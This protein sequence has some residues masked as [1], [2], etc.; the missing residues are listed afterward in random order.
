MGGAAKA[1]APGGLIPKAGIL[2]PGGRAPGNPFAV[3][4][5]KPDPGEGGLEAEPGVPAELILTG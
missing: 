4:V 1:A 3:G 2:G 5:G